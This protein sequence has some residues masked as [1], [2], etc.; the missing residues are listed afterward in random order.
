MIETS[1]RQQAQDA[2]WQYKGY[3]DHFYNFIWPCEEDP[4]RRFRIP[5]CEIEITGHEGVVQGFIDSENRCKAI[6]CMLCGQGQ[7]R[8]AEGEGER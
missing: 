3:Y 7:P 1:L 5:E 6:A 8:G 2:G 4:N